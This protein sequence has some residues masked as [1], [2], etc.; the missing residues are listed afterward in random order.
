MAD[1][2]R[3]HGNFAWYRDSLIRKIGIEKVEE[4]EK[5]KNIPKQR[6]EREL[7]DMIRDYK[8]KARALIPTKSLKVQKE[9]LGYLKVKEHKKWYE[10]YE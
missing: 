5:N 8:K 6:K 7:L 9:I 3:K 1:N 10:L 2:V 4:L